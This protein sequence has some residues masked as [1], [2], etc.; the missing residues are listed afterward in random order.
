MSAFG[1]MRIQNMQPDTTIKKGSDF[2]PASEQE[3]TCTIDDIYV[4][5]DGERAELIDRIPWQ[6]SHGLLYKTFF[7]WGGRSPGI[8]DC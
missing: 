6:Q 1:G 5:P 8:L 3:Q 2:L 4:L 7:V